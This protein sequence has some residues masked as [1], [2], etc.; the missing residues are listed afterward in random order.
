[1]S[2]LLYV[3]CF[4]YRTNKVA[5]VEQVYSHVELRA[6]FVL[7]TDSQNQISSVVRNIIPYLIEQKN[8][9]LTFS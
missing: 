8:K 6:L 5:C 9:K 3:N 2:H 1:M 4:V 7:E